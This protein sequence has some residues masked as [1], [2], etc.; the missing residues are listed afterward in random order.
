LTR[1]A[2]DPLIHMNSGKRCANFKKL[3][4]RLPASPLKPTP[5]SQKPEADL[6]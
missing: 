1:T 2:M 6:M 5:N 3:L 4:K